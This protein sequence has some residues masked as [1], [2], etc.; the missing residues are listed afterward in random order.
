MIINP[1]MFVEIEL[2]EVAFRYFEPTEYIIAVWGVRWNTIVTQNSAHSL[3]QKFDLVLPDIDLENE[4]FIVSMGSELERLDFDLNEPRYR[5]RGEFIGF[6]VF[7]RNYTYDLIVVYRT[8]IM[9]ITNAEGAGFITPYMG[10]GRE[11]G[12]WGWGYPPRRNLN[13]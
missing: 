5:E 6:P 1:P 3:A 8:D 12:A 9:R 13:E 2:E 7:S 4:M 10:R 11:H